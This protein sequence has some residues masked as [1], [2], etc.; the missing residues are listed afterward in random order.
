MSIEEREGFYRKPGNGLMV[1]L[2]FF[3]TMDMTQVSVHSGHD[4]Q[5][6]DQ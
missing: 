2:E 6:Q 1:E 5:I 3:G 4:P